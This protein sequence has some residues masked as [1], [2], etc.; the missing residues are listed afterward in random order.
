MKESRKRKLPL[1][2]RSVSASTKRMRT[3][4][5]NEG[6]SQLD[7]SVYRGDKDP[8][9]LGDN[10]G[11]PLD[12]IAWKMR[13]K[14]L[15]GVNDDDD[16]FR[17]AVQGLVRICFPQGVLQELGVNVVEQHMKEGS[18]PEEN[19]VYMRKIFQWEMIHRLAWM[20]AEH[21]DS[22][23]NIET[24][25]SS[26]IAATNRLHGQR[27]DWDILNDIVS[28]FEQLRDSLSGDATNQLANGG[29]LTLPTSSGGAQLDER[30]NEPFPSIEKVLGPQKQDQAADADNLRV[31]LA[32]AAAVGMDATDATAEMETANP[33]R[34]SKKKKK[35]PNNAVDVAT[36]NA[37]SS[38]VDQRLPKIRKKPNERKISRTW[39]WNIDVATFTS[40]ATPLHFKRV[41]DIFA[42]H[43]LPV[44]RS[45]LD[46]NATTD[47]IRGKL[48]EMLRE[49]NEEE[50]GQWRESLEKLEAGDLS[51]L[52]RNSADHRPNDDQITRATPA[53]PLSSPCMGKRFKARS[54]RKTKKTSTNDE[55]VAVGKTGIINE[56]NVSERL[57]I[58]DKVKVKSEFHNQVDHSSPTPLQSLE[59]SRDGPSSKEQKTPVTHS[60]SSPF[61]TP[62]VDVLWGN[63]VIQNHENSLVVGKLMEA[64][65]KRVLI[66]KIPSPSFGGEMSILNKR[67]LRRKLEYIVNK[68]QPPGSGLELRRRLEDALVPWI[69]ANA[70]WFPEV[71][72][73]PIIFTYFMPFVNPVVDLICGPN[74]DFS[75][76]KYNDL[77]SIVLS[78]LETKGISK[79]EHIGAREETIEAGVSHAIGS[80]SPRVR[81]GKLERVLRQIALVHT[82]KF[83]ELKKTDIV[84]KWE[85]MTGL[86]W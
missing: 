38:I 54:D 6:L 11:K 27:L 39:R 68:H 8:Q 16:V 7:R 36:Q 76:Q 14:V 49:M 82:N 70:S 33:R 86:R 47:E 75:Q 56:S 66:D 40:D 31:Q 17:D 41:S 60:R 42:F 35:E 22:P 37:S 69:G 43:A 61:G 4:S 65:H 62:L 51:M 59:E 78:T 55:Q 72:G 13:V 29:S 26:V 85:K 74:L 71:S 46:E 18:A 53:P 9:Y 30:E 44:V 12:H 5:T 52:E 50:F 83:P 34:K 19:V 64:L 48:D 79:R 77:K 20:L 63:T 28:A 15:C 58:Q 57:P 32:T 1:P 80:G 23:L 73:T 45:E 21:L 3:A 84:R 10:G 24:G 67:G 2:S 25:I 81:R